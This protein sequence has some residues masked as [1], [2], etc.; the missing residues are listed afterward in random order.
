MLIKGTTNGTV[1]NIDGEFSL[2]VNTQN[3]VLVFSYIGY[4]SQEMIV[5]NQEKINITLEENISELGE[6]VVM[7]YRSQKGATISGSVSPVDVSALESRRVPIVTQALQGQVA[8]VQVTQSTGAPGDEIEI[9]IRGNGTIGNNNPLYI[10]DGIPSREISFLNP[11]DIE[12]MTVLKDAAA[13]SIYGSRASAGVVVITTK[14]GTEG[15]GLQVNY[16]GGI[17]K[18]RN[19]PTMLNSSQYM[20]K[21]EEAWNNAGY[22]GTNPYTADKNRSDFA[23]TNWLNELFEVGTTHNLQLST[24]GGNDK[25]S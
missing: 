11:A 6:M 9:R 7:G 22:D 14:S 20:N 19:L 1:T 24:Q 15:S 3:A 8:G 16:F 25:T 4:S 21:V 10:I 18:V 2:S 17:Q 12:S 23:D 13:S 5:G